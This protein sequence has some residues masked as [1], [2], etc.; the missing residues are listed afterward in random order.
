MTSVPEFW[1]KSLQPSGKSIRCRAPPSFGEIP[2]FYHL[3]KIK[4]LPYSKE[5][6]LFIFLRVI[7]KHMWE[8]SK[9]LSLDKFAQL[10]L[11]AVVCRKWNY[12][13]TRIHIMDKISKDSQDFERVLSNLIALLDVPTLSPITYNLV[14][15]SSSITRMRACT[16]E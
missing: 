15:G 3:L 4:I 8:T 5:R 11:L 2:P 14:L 13:T 6:F 1:P 10:L 12:Q 7:F 16:P 9:N